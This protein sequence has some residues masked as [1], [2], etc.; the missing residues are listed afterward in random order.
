[1]NTRMS[2]HLVTIVEKSTSV[3]YGCTTGGIEMQQNPTK[4]IKQPHLC[5]A[6]GHAVCAQALAAFAYTENPR[7]D[8]ET[9]AHRGWYPTDRSNNRVTCWLLPNA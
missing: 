4:Q 3:A 8:P 2:D 6:P 9:Q 1:M 5:A 7:G